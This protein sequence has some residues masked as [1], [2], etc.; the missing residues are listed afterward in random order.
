MKT[1]LVHIHPLTKGSDFPK[2]MRSVSLRRLPSKF[3]GRSS[4]EPCINIEDTMSH[5][6]LLPFPRCTAHSMFYCESFFGCVSLAYLVLQACH[7]P[8]HLPMALL[9]MTYHLNLKPATWSRVIPTVKQAWGQVIKPKAMRTVTT[10]MSGLMM[11]I[12]RTRMCSY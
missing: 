11:L 2:H 9:P 10:V 12:W 5:Q 7:H 4:I 8:L 6:Y 1:H 3:Y